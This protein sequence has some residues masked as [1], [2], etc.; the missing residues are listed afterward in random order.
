MVCG[1]VSMN[2]KAAPGAKPASIELAAIS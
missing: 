1:V 2:G